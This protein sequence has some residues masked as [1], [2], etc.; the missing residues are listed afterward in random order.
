MLEMR[1]R[2]K[3]QRSAALVSPRSKREPKGEITKLKTVRRPM[4]GR[5]IEL[6]QAR[7]LDAD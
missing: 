2:K 1:P 4:Y 3:T 7:L 5:K 6:L